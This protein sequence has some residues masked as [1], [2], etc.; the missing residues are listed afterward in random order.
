MV[1]GEIPASEFDGGLGARRAAQREDAGHI[2]Q[3]TQGDAIDKILAATVD[4]IP[5]LD[6]VFAVLGDFIVQDWVRV[7][8]VMVGVL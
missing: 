5:D 4:G 8:Q 6:D 7:E 3:L 1:T 2:R